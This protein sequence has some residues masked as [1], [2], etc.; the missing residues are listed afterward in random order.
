MVNVVDFHSFWPGRLDHHAPKQ[1]E[2]GPPTCRN[3]ALI[4]RIGSVHKPKLI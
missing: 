3:Y 2:R 4:E 1:I